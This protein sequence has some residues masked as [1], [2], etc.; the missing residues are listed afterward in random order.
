MATLS[1]FRKQNLQ[2]IQ[3]QVNELIS[4]VTK[5][6]PSDENFSIAEDFIM[7]N[8]QHNS[9]Q[10]TNEHDMR[11]M[12]TALEQKQIVHNQP[13]RAARMKYLVETFKTK[14]MKQVGI[15]DAHMSMLHLLFLL[16][17]NPVGP[18]GYIDENVRG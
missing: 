9:F 10:D 7:Q 5:L 1:T 15:S 6:E 13:E 16:A 17:D 2:R 8:I 14:P 3:A 11:R 4:H 12:I 18:D